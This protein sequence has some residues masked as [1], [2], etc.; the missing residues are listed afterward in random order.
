MA[1]VLPTFNVSVSIFTGVFPFVGPRLVVMGNLALGKRVTI[2]NSAAFYGAD[3][4]AGSVPK[5]LLPAATDIR[6]AAC[7]NLP[8]VVEIPSGSGRWYQVGLVDDI[9]K[10]FANE[11]RFAEL[12]KLWQN[13]GGIACPGLFWPTPIP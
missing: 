6:D 3:G 4:L 10:G 1:F 9:G 12:A 2:Y 8:D 13:S 5:I 7:S 11:H